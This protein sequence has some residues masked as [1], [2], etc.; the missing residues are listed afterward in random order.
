MLPTLKDGDFPLRP[1][2]S[3]QLKSRFEYPFAN[4]NPA[5]LD[6]NVL[7][8][9]S[10]LDERVKLDP[11]LFQGS[12]F[13]SGPRY[14]LGGGRVAVAKQDTFWSEEGDHLLEKA[15]VYFRREPGRIDEI[16]LTVTGLRPHPVNHPELGRQGQ[17]G[18]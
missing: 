14:P 2:R 13:P 12:L 3:Y 1:F 9:P 11:G 8:L 5:S 16:L 4:G 10:E 15:L 6:T 17:L 7:A 18:A